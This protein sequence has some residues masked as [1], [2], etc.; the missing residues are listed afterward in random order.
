MSLLAEK[1]LLFCKAF[2][3]GGVFIPAVRTQAA[4]AGSQ[5]M[6]RE[7]VFETVC[8]CVYIPVYIRA[9]FGAVLEL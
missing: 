9:G 5:C 4:T 1:M 8:V 3:V 2:R 6:L 7:Y